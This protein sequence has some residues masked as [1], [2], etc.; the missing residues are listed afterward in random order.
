MRESGPDFLNFIKNCKT[1]NLM[2]SR[3]KVQKMIQK[4][5]K[6]DL[7]NVRFWVTEMTPQTTPKMTPWGDP[8]IVDFWSDVADT[9]GT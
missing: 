2:F 1:E 4:W 6:S 9:N 7:E 5:S 3:K 8:K